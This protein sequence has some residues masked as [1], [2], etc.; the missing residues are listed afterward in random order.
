MTITTP[1]IP[2]GAIVPYIAPSM[3]VFPDSPTDT[4]ESQKEGIAGVFE[5]LGFGVELGFN[6]TC[7]TNIFVAITATAPPTLVNW[8]K[9][10]TE[11]MSFGL[12]LQWSIG[13]LLCV[14]QDFYEDSYTQHL[15]HTGKA[16]KTLLNWQSVA[17]SFPTLGKNHLIDTYWEIDRKSVV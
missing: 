1:S 9:A 5:R 4:P 13:D 6:P 2:E 7:E 14:G 11:A 15:P 16:V 17:R 12:G 10:I 3:L 8:Q